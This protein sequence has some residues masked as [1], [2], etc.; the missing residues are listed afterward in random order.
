[1]ILVIFKIPRV[2]AILVA[3]LWSQFRKNKYVFG[4]VEIVS[5]LKYNFLGSMTVFFQ[6]RSKR[7]H[8]VEKI[9]ISWVNLENFH[10]KNFDPNIFDI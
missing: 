7:C 3:R 4:G 8:I 1:M 6:I 2:R 10:S 9:K 5:E